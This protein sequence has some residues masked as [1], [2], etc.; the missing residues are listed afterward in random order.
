M[1]SEFRRAARLA[2]A[3]AVPVMLLAGLGVFA[4]FGGFASDDHTDTPPARP[5]STAPVAMPKI[6][7]TARQTT[8]CLAFTSQLPAQLR[9]LKA[10][11]VTA[12]P[13]QNAAFGD[14]AIT[15][16]CGG[17]QPTVGLTDKVWQLD[18][19]CWHEVDAAD[20]TTWTTI[21]R[22]VPVTVTV[23]ADYAAATQWVIEFSTPVAAT[24][25][26]AGPLPNGCKTN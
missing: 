16:A 12:G 17:R 24:I 8:V 7:L 3:I 26:S 13:E 22:E 4:A 21:G 1:D 11:P 10:R 14:P 5:Q 15:A 25:L 9:S 20:H 23:P 19:V 6:A 2:T 18:A